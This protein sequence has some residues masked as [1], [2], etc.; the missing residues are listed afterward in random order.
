[1]LP[2]PAGTLDYLAEIGH[3]SYLFTYSPMTG[4]LRHWETKWDK[5]GRSTP[6]QPKLGGGNGP[7]LILSSLQ[8]NS[9]AT[10]GLYT[11]RGAL[12]HYVLNDYEHP[13]Y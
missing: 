4:W 8:D 12:R 13:A 5:L 3:G 6:Y 9:Y 11:K 10:I 1:M 7:K 2:T